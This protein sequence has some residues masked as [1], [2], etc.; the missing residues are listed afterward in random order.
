M[1]VATRGAVTRPATP[2]LPCRKGVRPR[3]TPGNAKGGGCQVRFTVRRGGR[4]TF[5]A[6]E[7]AT[8]VVMAG[9]PGNGYRT[10]TLPKRDRTALDG[11][12]RLEAEGMLRVSW[13]PGW[14]G[15]PGCFAIELDDARLVK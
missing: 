2:R 14:G 15:F 13:L 1:E 8:V 7:P 3:W 9:E 10:I 11:G 4:L 5:P 12:A 6:G